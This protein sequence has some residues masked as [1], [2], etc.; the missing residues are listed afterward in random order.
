MAYWCSLC[1]SAQRHST[2]AQPLT[3]NR[4][5]RCAKTTTA[6]QRDEGKIE[7]NS[8]AVV[9]SGD[10]R[11]AADSMIALRCLARATDC[12][13]KRLRRKPVHRG[14]CCS[15]SSFHFPQRV[16]RVARSWTS[17]LQVTT[18]AAVF[19]R[20]N[21]LMR[22]RRGSLAA[23]RADPHAQGARAVRGSSPRAQRRPS[24]RRALASA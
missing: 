12:S 21:R 23:R 7:R 16:S 18:S 10:A 9:L 11:R 2:R 15:H 5:Q 1:V 17:D 8:G 19:P 3:V 6:N 22:T 4:S 20:V 24:S 13:A 14:G